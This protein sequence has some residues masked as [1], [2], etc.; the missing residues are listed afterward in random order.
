MHQHLLSPLEEIRHKAATMKPAK[1]PVSA[2]AE[3]QNKDMTP[4]VS[5]D[6][7][8]LANNNDLSIQAIANEARRI[9][10]QESEEVVIKLH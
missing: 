4:P 3:A 1:L 5:P 8:R 2:P 10:E 7:M 6:I 9:S